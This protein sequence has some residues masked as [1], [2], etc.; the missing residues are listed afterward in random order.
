MGWL[1]QVCFSPGAGQLWRQCV[2]LENLGRQAER[3]P[4]TSSFPHGRVFLA[5][6]TTNHTK[7]ARKALRCLQCQEARTLKGAGKQTH[8]PQGSALLSFSIGRDSPFPAMAVLSDLTAAGGLDSIHDDRLPG[9]EPSQQHLPEQCLP[10][11]TRAR[12]LATG[13]RTRSPTRPLQDDAA[14]VST[15]SV[16]VCFR[17][18]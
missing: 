5:I 15:P 8:S 16:R 17:Q 13:R 18:F 12:W 3:C 4:G 14:P 9:R 10:G 1:A 2:L 6:Q 7:S 11:G